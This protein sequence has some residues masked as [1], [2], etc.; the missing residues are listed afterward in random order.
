MISWWSYIWATIV[1]VQKYMEVPIDTIAGMV[2]FLFCTDTA[3]I[4]IENVL[5]TMPQIMQNN[6]YISCEKM[7]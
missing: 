5:T 4:V 1:I 3:K 6:V 2:A 7:P